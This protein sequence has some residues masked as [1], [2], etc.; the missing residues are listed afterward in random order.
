MFAHGFYI[1]R[2]RS[3]SQPS[4]IG[5]SDDPLLCCNSQAQTVLTKRV[6][7]A[8]KTANVSGSRRHVRGRRDA[9]SPGR[10][11][12]SP[13]GQSRHFDRGPAPS[14]LPQNNGHRQAVRG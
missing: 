1:I 2:P 5:A 9:V 4:K 10:G 8:G 11:Q 6:S 14:G 7:I 12:M 13:V 3:G